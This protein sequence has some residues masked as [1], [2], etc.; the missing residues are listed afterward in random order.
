VP[1]ATVNHRSDPFAPLLSTKLHL[2][3]PRSHLVERLQEG[4]TGTLTLVSAPAGFGKTMLLAQW[5][6]AMRLPAAWLSLEPEDNDPTRF[7]TYLVAAL[8]ARDPHL[9]APALALLRRPQPAE[10][11]TVLTLLTNDLMNWRGE[12]FVLVLDD[13]HIIE[14]PPI[15]A[16]LAF[17]LEH[18]PPRMHLVIAA[19]RSTAA[20]GP[21]AGTRSADRAAGCRAALWSG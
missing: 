11:Q 12:A 10:H 17:L 9:G 13:Y 19:R 16:A 18:Q 6:A 3:R 2:P 14:V 15:H 4:T 7:L 20:T 1:L 8:R 21:T 5:L